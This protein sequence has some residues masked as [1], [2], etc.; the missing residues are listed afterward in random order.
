M[1]ASLDTH[2][3]EAAVVFDYRDNSTA[4]RFDDGF[5]R[6]Q[7]DIRAAGRRDLF[8]VLDFNWLKS[9]TLKLPRMSALARA[10]QAGLPDTPATSIGDKCL[11]SALAKTEETREVIVV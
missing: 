10:S 1:Q 7:Q 5:T 3:P 8:Q 4:S 2:R 6:Y 9:L 11:Q